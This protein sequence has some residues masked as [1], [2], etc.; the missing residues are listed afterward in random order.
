MTT[1]DRAFA[2]KTKF[3]VEK[4]ALEW[5]VAAV[6]PESRCS[7]KRA[8]PIL[9]GVACRTDL[10]TDFAIYGRDARGSDGRPCI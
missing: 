3:V 5:M 9:L 1:S 7:E 6:R 8:S 4:I 10:V 2:G